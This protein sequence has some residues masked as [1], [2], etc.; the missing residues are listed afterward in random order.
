MVCNIIQGKIVIINIKK[1]IFAISVL[2]VFLIKTYTT[3]WYEMSFFVKIKLKIKTNF[4]WES[5]K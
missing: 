1:C 3:P 5:K 2:Q 4:E